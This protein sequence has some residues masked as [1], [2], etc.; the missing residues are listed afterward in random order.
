MYFSI[1][2]L[3][4]GDD[5]VV[6]VGYYGLVL[7]WIWFQGTMINSVVGAVSTVLTKE[8]SW[9]TKASESGWEV[10]GLLWRIFL[11]GYNPLGDTCMDSPGIHN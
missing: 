1:I 4:M 2:L 9:E 7:T 8:S 6:I 11:S 3:V 10:G 5:L